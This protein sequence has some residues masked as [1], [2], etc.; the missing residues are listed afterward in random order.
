MTGVTERTGRLKD[1]GIGP[2][3]LICAPKGEAGPAAMQQAPTKDQTAH[4]TTHTLG[5]CDLKKEQ[6]RGKKPKRPTP[7]KSNGAKQT[8]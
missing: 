6:G 4:R 1:R 7:S 2:N 8:V 3:Y 5:T